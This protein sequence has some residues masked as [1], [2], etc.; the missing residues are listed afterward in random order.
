MKQPLLPESALTRLQ[1]AVLPGAGGVDGAGLVHRAVAGVLLR[2]IDR[3]IPSLRLAMGDD[4]FEH[5]L[6]R[7]F[8][9]MDAAAFLAGEDLALPPVRRDEYEE[10]LHLLAENCSIMSEE[11][12]WASAVVALACQGQQHLWQDLGL[13][14]RNMLSQLMRSCFGSL[15]ELNVNDMKWKKFLYKRLCELDG[16]RCRAPSCRECSDFAN[17]YGPEV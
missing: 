9:P 15:A 2:I 7:C 4:G 11:G 17:C 3:Q 12:E 13:E 10:V 16:F 6:M 1:E 14:N 5:M 8:P